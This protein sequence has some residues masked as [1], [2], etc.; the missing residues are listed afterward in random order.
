MPDPVTQVL[1]VRD[2]KH[3][4]LGERA[5]VIFDLVAKCVNVDMR[6]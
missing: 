4:E 5:R 2:P 6:W 1:Y 3:F